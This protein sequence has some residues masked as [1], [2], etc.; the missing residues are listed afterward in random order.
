MLCD[1][2]GVDLNFGRLGE[3]TDKLQ[4][5]LIRQAASEP[6]EGFLKIVVASRAQIIILEVPLPVE[7]DLLR[8]NLAILHVNLFKTAA[9]EQKN[10]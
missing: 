5:G 10:V 6:E 3:L 4:I 2:S 9:K 1:K 7:L 8:F